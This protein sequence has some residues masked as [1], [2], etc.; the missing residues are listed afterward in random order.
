MNAQ[1][2]PTAYE[3][4][5]ANRIDAALPKGLALSIAALFLGAAIS[6]SPA[7]AAKTVKALDKASA[8]PAAQA[9]LP[10]QGGYFIHTAVEGDTLIKLAN[11]YL[12]KRHLWQP[13]QKLNQIEDPTRIKPGTQIRIPIPDMRREAVDLK[14]LAAQGDVLVDGGKLAAGGVVKEGQKINTGDNGFVTVQLADGSTLT[15]QSKSQVKV[16]SARQVVNTG[17]MLDSVFRVVSGRVEAGVERQRGPAARFEVK[18]DTSTMGV[19]GTRFRVAAEEGGKIARSEVIEGKVGV[20]AEG[21]KAAELPVE[22]GFGTVVEAGKAPLPPVALLPAP[23]LPEGALRFERP[24]IRYQATP[25]AG[26]QAYRLLVAADAA[27]KDIRADVRADQPTFTLPALDDGEYRLRVRAIDKL[28]LEGRDA[29]RSFTLA[30]RP[31]PPALMNP[32]P[33]ARLALANIRFEWAASTEATRYH[34]QVA[35]DA[36]FKEPLVS[37]ASLGSNAFALSKALPSGEYVWRLAAITA[38]GKQGPW[39]DAAKFR[40]QADLADPDVPQWVGGK[41]RFSWRGE[42]GIKYQFQLATDSHFRRV[43]VDRV[44]EQPEVILDRPAVG[45]YYMRYRLA[46]AAG[47]TPFSGTQ[48]VDVYP[49]GR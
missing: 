43:A 22:G 28:G 10:A 23:V 21:V 11:R 38:L 30:A 31:E 44:T 36:S 35:K 37:E 49:L 39:S 7:W 15:V 25:V 24:V 17:G 3:Y 27:F 41:L 14:V 46:D 13:L 1:S 33:D 26:A 48:V 6:A 16:D 19:R 12:Q 47:S 20:S 45:V 5:Q 18:T 32:A 4:S 42:A 40:V 8:A 9:V 2:L 29:E 34:L